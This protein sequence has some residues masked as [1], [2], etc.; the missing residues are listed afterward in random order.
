MFQANQAYAQLSG[1]FPILAG[2]GPMFGTIL[3]I[4]V[5]VVIIGGIKSIANVTEKIVP[6][7]ATLSIRLFSWGSLSLTAA[8]LN[9]LIIQLHRF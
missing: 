8:F 5:G 1:Q 7:M 3:A 4:L 6:F 2:N 9:Y